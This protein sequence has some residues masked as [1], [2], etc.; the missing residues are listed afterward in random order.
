MKIND[1]L[2]YGSSLVLDWQPAQG[3]FLSLVWYH[4][5]RCQELWQPI[6]GL[7]GGQKKINE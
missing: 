6:T 4:W 1:S 2:Y 3:V 5:E 7:S